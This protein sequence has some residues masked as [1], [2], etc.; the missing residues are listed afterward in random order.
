[1]V[2]VMPP[3]SN[4]VHVVVDV[5]HYEDYNNEVHDVFLRLHFDVYVIEMV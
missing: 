1:M 5:M 2:V 4:Q 3:K